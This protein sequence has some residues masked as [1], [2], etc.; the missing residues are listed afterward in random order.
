MRPEL[1]PPVPA[2]VVWLAEVDSTN[3]VAARL[4]A[5]WVEDEDDRLGDTLLVAGTQ[6]AGRG[7]GDHVWA[8]PPGG[9]Y[10]TWLGWISAAEL[11]WL[12]IAAG[13][14]LAAA[15]EDAL[16]GVAAGLKWPNDILVGGR[17]LAGVLCLSRSRGDS[18]W[19]AVGVGVNVDG[20]PAMTAGAAPGATSLRSLGFA[21]DAEAAIWT[22]ARGFVH[23]LR[24]ALAQPAGLSAA[25]LA[26]AVHRPGDTLRVRKGDE[27]IVGAFAGL[28]ANGHLEV[29]AGGRVQHI[30][31]GELVGDIPAIEAEE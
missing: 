28:G 18:A 9:L 1:Q 30:A 29:A 25:W 17:K 23:R 31:A 27:V 5:S 11:G 6:T 21:G 3:Q 8:S 2:N 10:A 12:P 26:R 16:P 19:A 7:R 13:I 24:P 22:V 15:I 4:V 20:T 14:C